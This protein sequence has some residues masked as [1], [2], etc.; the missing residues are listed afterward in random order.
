MRRTT[1][2]TCVAALGVLAFAAAVALPARADHPVRDPA[3]AQQLFDRAKELQAAGDW[4]TACAKF[5]ASMDLN[6]ATGTLIRIARC[7]EHEGKLARAWADYHAALALNRTL[8]GQTDQRREELR[9]L[10]EKELAALEPRLP[11]LRVV[12]PAAPPGLKLSRDDQPLP[13]A[14]LGDELPV[15]PGRVEVVAEAPGYLTARREAVAIEGQVTVVEIAL[16]R[17]PAVVPAPIGPSPAVSPPVAPEAPPAAAQPPPPSPDGKKQRIAGIAVGSVGVASLGAGAGLTALAF[18]AYAQSSRYCPSGN[19][20][21]QHGL[22][23]RNDARGALAGAYAAFGV[24]VAAVTVGAVLFAKAPRAASS[25]EA[26][27]LA[28][29]AGPGNVSLQGCF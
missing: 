28:V 11:K 29:T 14:A 12:V 13:V 20:C 22:D 7:R 2:T 25:P 5:Q 27:H 16:E 15:D 18:S 9:L 8:S 1:G 21:Y 24:G 23:L 3:A 4:P 17:A 19:Q 10:I 26:A 6:P